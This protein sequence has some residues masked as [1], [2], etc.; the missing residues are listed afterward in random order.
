MLPN[1]AVCTIAIWVLNAIAVIP[2]TNW[3]FRTSLA[4]AGGLAVE[5]AGEA[6]ATKELVV[7]HQRLY[8]TKYIQADL[9]VMGI[10]GFIAGLAGLQMIG[11]AWKAKAWPGLLAM[12]AASFMGY[13]FSR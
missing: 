5:G 9:I 2:L 12:I 7:Q 4:R 8:T 3:L 1:I 10:A 6:V 13:A 11:L